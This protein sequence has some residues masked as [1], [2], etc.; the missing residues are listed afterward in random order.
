VIIHHE[1][2]QINED[3]LLLMIGDPGQYKLGSK[4]HV[5]HSPESVQQLLLG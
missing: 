2:Q 1:D 4:W 5:I 3:R